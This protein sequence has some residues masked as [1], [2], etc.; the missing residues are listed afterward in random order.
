MALLGA[1]RITPKAALA[2]PSRIEVIGVASRDEERAQAF[3]KQHRVG[4]AYRSYREALSDPAVE[5]VYLATPCS[6]HVPWTLAALEA[7]K[8]VLTE[9]PFALSREDAARAVSRAR[10]LDRVLVEAHHTIF[11]PLTASFQEAVRL[12][13]RVTGVEV[14]FDAAIREEHDIRL[15]PKLG[16]GV[17]LDFGGYLF[18][19]LEWVRRARDP[20]RTMQPWDMEVL[21]ASAT[22]RPAEVDRSFE[23]EVVCHSGFESFPA[24]LSTTMEPE[25]EFQA[26]IVVH[27]SSARV[28]FENPLALEGSF[29]DRPASERVHARGPT[30]YAGQL[31]GFYRAVRRRE[32]THH[33]GEEILALHGLL[34]SAYL[35]AG[36]SLRD[37]LSKR[38]RS[39]AGDPPTG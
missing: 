12:L 39:E 15:D 33:T 19:W 17:L 34:D 37:A 20:D 38:A 16:A 9:K 26:R 35:R 8:H 5:A 13:D 32:P 31:E 2:L 1:A 29:L 23:A 30:T 28:R 10:E 25:S 11:H 18:A 22:C 36:L 6:E 27:G 4:R 3:A 14:V 7:G 21:S 24:W